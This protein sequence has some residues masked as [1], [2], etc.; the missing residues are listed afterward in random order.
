M[1][2]NT[3]Q[4]SNRFPWREFLL[5]LA[6][7][8]L[9]VALQNVLTTTASMVDTIMLA[10]CG[11]LTVGAVGLCGQFSSLMLAGYWGFVG[12]GM[13]FF[14]QYFGA[15]KHESICHSFGIVL[16]CLMSVGF[17]FGLS[18]IFAPQVIMGLYTDKTAIQEIGIRYLR[19]VGFAYPLQTLAQAQCALLRSTERVRIPLIASIAALVTNFICNFILIYGRLGFPVLGER[20]AAIGTL[21]AA[22][23]NVALILILARRAH[24]P[25]LLRF[26]EHFKFGKEL[27]SEFFRKCYPILLNEVLIGICNMVINVVIGHQAE[28]AIVATA[29]FRTLEGFVLAFFSGFTSAASVLIG[30]CV[31]AGEHEVAYQRALRLVRLVPATVFCVVLILLGVRNPMLHAMGLRDRSYGICVSMLMIYAVMGSIRMTNW[32]QNDTFRAAGD[33]VFGTVREIIF[34]YAMIIPAMLISGVW[35]KLPFLN[36]FLCSYI[37][38]PIRVVLMLRHTYSGKWIKPVT[39]EGMATLEE[40]RSLHTG[41]SQKRVRETPHNTH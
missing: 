18:A 38:E 33:P 29:V 30:T 24:E 25:Y 17:L 26:R 35:L 27:V 16:I 1:Q 19:I 14:A 5:Q 41:T 32:I 9:P 6:A 4:N 36:V 28:E 34:A 31:G 20:G 8:A 12:G 15:K 2:T 7:I 21:M 10:S 3:L 22:I 37:D 13:L 40:F 23:V 11:D 39:P